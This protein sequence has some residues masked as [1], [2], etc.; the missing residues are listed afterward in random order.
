M[1]AAVDPTHAHLPLPGGRAGASVVVEPL[2]CG[3][4]SAP[5]GFYDRPDGRLG[6]VRGLLAPRSKW[7]WVPVPVFLVRHPS[8]G[9]ILI[10]TGLHPTAALDPAANFGPLLG[11][12]Q[13]VRLD[14]AEAAPERLASLSVDPSEVRVFILTH[15][16]FDHAS[17]IS[18]FP[19]A[20]FVVDREE[21]DA[22]SNG[23]ARDGY[24]SRQFDHAFDW[25]TI[26]FESRSVDSFA[27][28]GRSV[29]LFGDGSVRLLSTPGHSAGHMSVL[30]ALAAGG[31][32]LVCG[33]AMY[34]RESLHSDLRPLFVHDP[35]L[36]RRSLREIRQYAQQTPGATIVPGH[37][38]RAWQTIA[39][40]Y[41]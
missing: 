22:A 31:E 29:D 39:A 14:R 36:Y 17:A 27:T 1:S 37:D 5:P 7:F 38:P 12:L 10:D 34:S 6:Y 4:V 26:D 8:V 16:H 23:G 24:R 13:R 20:T 19:R 32:L 18:E 30:L 35:H 41:A 9:T 40:R 25:Q 15:L 33:D 11:R 21:W 2:R 3:E 28:F